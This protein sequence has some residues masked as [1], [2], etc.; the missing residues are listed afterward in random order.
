MLS[1]ERQNAWRKRYRAERPGWRP[2]TELYADLVRE[3]L[4]PDGCLLDIGCGRGGLV[5]QLGHPPELIVGVDP[6]YDSLCEHR[7]GIP[8]AVAFSDHLPLAND[9]FDTAV[10][11]WVLEHLPDPAADFREIGRVLRPGGRFLFITPNKRHPLI[12]LNRGLAKFRFAQ[13]RLV[14]GF[15]GRAAADTFPA[16]YRANTAVDLQRLTAQA[17]LT[18][19]SL[20]IVADPTYLLF[21]P[22]LFRPLR[23]W[24]EWLEKERGVH[25]VGVSEKVGEE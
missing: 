11:S 18:L 12:G 1:L 20:H 6:D 16:Y 9:Q 10:A 4:P 23:R 17:G 22:A 24:E 14:S 5:E 7:L 13:E 25:L 3:Y 8:R 19:T 21:H 15:Y 2:A